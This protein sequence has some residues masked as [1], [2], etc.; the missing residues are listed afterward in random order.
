VGGIGLQSHAC[1]LWSTID[2]MGRLAIAASILLV[3]TYGAEAAPKKKKKKPKHKPDTTETDAGKD[4]A[5][6]TEIEMDAPDPQA[7]PAAGE[8][9]PEPTAS[10]TAT[11]TAPP[12]ASTAG[13]SF[14]ERPL[15]QP[16]DKLDLHGGLPIVVVPFIDNSGNVTTQASEGLTIGATYGIDDKTEIGGDYTVLLNPSSLKGLFVVHTAY[17]VLHD[18]KMDLAIAGALE[19]QPVD[20]VGATGM[21]T[22]STFL[23]LQVGAWFRYHLQPKLSLFSGL[24]ALPHSGISLSHQGVALPPVGYQLGIGLNN[25]GPIGLEL[26]IGVG[27]QA[28]PSFYGF[29]ATNLAN[30]GIA[31]VPNVLL[32]RDF[33]PLGIGGFYAMPKLDLGAVFADDLKQPG[34][35]LSFSILA[36]YFL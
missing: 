6:D 17:A 26:P 16:K 35:Y 15:T 23:S 21:T 14:D 12:T 10:V 3:M 2:P 34:N 36:R 30:I 27:Y 31:N 29:A 19:I 32:F 11:T 20:T 22:T 1:R 4:K 18:A 33:I 8:S 5:G 25:S 9:A 7:K 24:P 28:S 13:L